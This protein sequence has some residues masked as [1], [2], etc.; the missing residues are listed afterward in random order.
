MKI[1]E[2]LGVKDVKIEVR[3]DFLSFLLC[4]VRLLSAQNGVLVVKG[5]RE[6]GGG[7]G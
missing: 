5:K 2:H 1:L 7:R 4:F 3:Y 6:N